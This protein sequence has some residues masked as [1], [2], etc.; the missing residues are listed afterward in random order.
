VVAD[1]CHETPWRADGRQLLVLVV[2]AGRVDDY[3]P[4]QG[5]RPSKCAR[6]SRRHKLTDALPQRRKVIARNPDRYLDMV[7]A[8]MRGAFGLRTTAPQ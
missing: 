2:V 6:C 8:E 4:R 5:R 7:P 1:M 3:R